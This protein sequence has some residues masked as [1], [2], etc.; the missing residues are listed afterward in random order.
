MAAEW[1]DLSGEYD[2]V[3]LGVADLIAR[4]GFLDKVFARQLVSP[5]QLASSRRLSPEDGARELLEILMRQSSD[6]YKKFFDAIEKTP[7]SDQLL[8]IF[9]RHS[10]S[11]KSSTS[12]SGL[13]KAN[14]STSANTLDGILAYKRFSQKPGRWQTRYLHCI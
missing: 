8:Q 3:V 1:R 12:D 7:N 13:V 9:R 10:R 5:E 6:S 14:G 2:V 11:E 4:G